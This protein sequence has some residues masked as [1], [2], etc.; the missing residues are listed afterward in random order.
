MSIFICPVCGRP[1]ER[2]G[3]A[4]VCQSKHSFDIAKE[5][6]VN[7]ITGTK[8]GER[9]GDDK[10]SVRSRRDFLNKGYYA[11][12]KNRLVELFSDKKG[13]LLD[14]CCGEGYY[15][16]AI[17]ENPGIKV[18]GFDISKEA[19]RL[20]AKRGNGSFFAA[21]MTRLPVADGVIDYATLLFAPFCGGEIARTMRDNGELYLVIPGKRHLFGLKE[22]LY[23]QPYEN[24]E[25][26]PTDSGFM[27]DGY[28]RIYDKVTVSSNEDIRSVLRMTPYFFRTSEKDKEKLCGVGQLDTEVEFLI[29]K[30]LK[31]H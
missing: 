1:L 2:S 3:S 31:K 8:S 28:E 24:D 16:S 21:N 15:S 19:V 23:E 6:Y 12:L 29:G 18:Y 27:L 9:M 30:Y 20:A 11:S 26:F 14:V 13:N 10:I 25:K 22:L 5:G 7:L 17:G 4:L